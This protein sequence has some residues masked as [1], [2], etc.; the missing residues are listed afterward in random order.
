MKLR[1]IKLTVVFAMLLLAFLVLARAE[2]IP[3]LPDAAESGNAIESQATAEAASQVIEL[4]S[5]EEI[6]SLEDESFNA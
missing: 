1:V 5:D 3:A 2:D 4:L 6:S